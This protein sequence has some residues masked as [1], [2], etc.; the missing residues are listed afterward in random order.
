MCWHDLIE[1]VAGRWKVAAS[2]YA[3]DSLSGKERLATLCCTTVMKSVFNSRK[4]RL[5]YTA[6]FRGGF[7]SATQ[8]AHNEQ[9]AGTDWVSQAH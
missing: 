7:Q 4:K 3:L 6:R 9:L 8:I 1:A 5:G 2:G